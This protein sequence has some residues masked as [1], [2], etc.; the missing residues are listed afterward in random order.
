[1][2]FFEQDGV[3]ETGVSL[4]YTVRQLDAGPV[5][6]YE[7]VEIDDQIKVFTACVIIIIIFFFNFFFSHARVISHRLHSQEAHITYYSRLTR[8]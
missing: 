8:V 2:N 5:I 1:M 6:S 7:K 4:A 3:T